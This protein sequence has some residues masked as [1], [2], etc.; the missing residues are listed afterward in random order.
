MFVEFIDSG[1]IG[2]DEFVCVIVVFVENVCVVVV[3]DVGK[4]V[5]VVVIVL[6]GN[7]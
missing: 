2:V 3:V 4:S 7:N 6:N 1:V 5:D